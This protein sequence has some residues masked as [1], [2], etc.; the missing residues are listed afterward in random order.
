MLEADLESVLCRTQ[1]KRGCEFAMPMQYQSVP[2][3]GLQG[4]PY[5]LTEPT[6][7]LAI[8]YDKA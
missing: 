5:I 8:L 6:Y 1:S 3:E 4:T 2:R 7:R